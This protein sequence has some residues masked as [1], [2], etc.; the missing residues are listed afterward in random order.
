MRLKKEFAKNYKVLQLDGG[1]LKGIMFLVFLTELERLIGYKCHEMFDLIIGT[2]TGGITA[3][4][5]ARG[6]KAETILE[7]YCKDG[8]K[9]F[10][11]RWFGYANPAS[12]FTGSRYKRKYVDALAKK[13]MNYP[14]NKAKC[15]LIVTGVNMRDARHT[16]FFK[17][18]KFKYAD[19]K[20]YA[21]VWATYSAPTYFGYFKDKKDLLNTGRKGGGVWADG[22]IGIQNCTLLQAYGEVVKQKKLDN[23]WILSCGCGYTG[24]SDCKSFILSQI[25]D[26]IPV[27]REQSIISQIKYAEEIL[28]ANFYRIDLALPKK[29]I[30]MD[31]PKY[32]KK[33]LQYGK[34][35]VDEHIKY[36][37]EE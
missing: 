23:Y 27:A 34:L 19:V 1:G 32:T 16:H 24:L 11:K 30:A 36:L 33:Y 9:I 8:K 15:D 3:A 5:L 17:S 29:Y 25:K 10:N 7:I 22:G 4:L 21:A 20:T 14:M 2:S 35:L 6:I 12:W 31:K 26:F 18:Y 28:N 37:L 13:Y